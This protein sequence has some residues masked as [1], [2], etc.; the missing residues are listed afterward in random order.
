MSDVMS[1]LEVWQLDNPTSS[2]D[3]AVEWL[4]TEKTAGRIDFGNSRS[5]DGNGGV[6]AKKVKVEQ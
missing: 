4:Q 3:A 2:K 6:P 1:R 5:R